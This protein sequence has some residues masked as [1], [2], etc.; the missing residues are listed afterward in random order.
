[1]SLC[2][3]SNPFQE[4]VGVPESSLSA[5]NAQALCQARRVLPP[6]LLLPRGPWQHPRWKP[7][8][9]RWHD[10][11]AAAQVAVLEAIPAAMNGDKRYRGT[12][13]TAGLRARPPAFEL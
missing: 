1:M 2:S 8:P 4:E 10:A 6:P 13:A 7:A 3:V 5:P 12:V 9:L 11:L